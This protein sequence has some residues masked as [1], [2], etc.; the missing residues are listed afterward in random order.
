MVFH[1]RHTFD[2]NSIKEF[3]LH[4]T[5]ILHEDCA[6]LRS[7]FSYLAN[8]LIALHYPVYFYFPPDYLESLTE[9]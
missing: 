8:V 9:H 3:N 4:E 2:V 6:M 5:D 7:S 1:S